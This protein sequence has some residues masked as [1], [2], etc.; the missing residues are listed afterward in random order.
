MRSRTKWMLALLV[1][2]I[3]GIQFARPARTN[4]PEEFS[5]SIF[6]DA[7]VWQ[8][9]PKTIERACMDCH[10]S[11]T[12]WPWYSNVAPVS[13]LVA[14]DVAKGRERFSLSNWSK[15]NQPQKIVLL[16]DVCKLVKRHAMPLPIYIPM[17]AE[18]KL[19]EQER[20]EICT[21]SEHARERVAAGG[22]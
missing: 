1:V 17:H 8:D 12:R 18:A 3:V 10:S 6:A 20:E 15:Y 9:A 19:T 21:W 5:K 14:D 4:P 7:A 11:R 22:K 2:L 13:W 16:E